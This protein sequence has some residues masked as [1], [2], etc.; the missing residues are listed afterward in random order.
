MLNYQRVDRRN[1]HRSVSSEHPRADSPSFHM[2]CSHATYTPMEDGDI[3][4]PKGY[5]QHEWTIL[6][7]VKHHSGTLPTELDPKLNTGDLRQ[8]LMDLRHVQH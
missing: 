4:E 2:R 7:Y 3:Q 5:H 6:R 1:I 8:Q